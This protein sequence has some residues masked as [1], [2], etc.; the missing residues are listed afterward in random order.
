MRT[1]NSEEVASERMLTVLLAIDALQVALQLLPIAWACITGRNRL[2]TVGVL[3]AIRTASSA[4]FGLV[5]GASP[6]ATTWC[7]T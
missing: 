3:V 2:T 5:V 4:V 6:A 7:P 1:A